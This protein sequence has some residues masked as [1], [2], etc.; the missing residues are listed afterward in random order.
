MASYPTYDPS[1]WIGGVTQE[2]VQG[3]SSTATRCR[4]TPTRACSP[5]ARR[6]RSSA[7]PRP[8]R[9][10]STS[11]GYVPL[12]EPG[13]RRR[14]RRSATSSRRR[15]AP[16]RL[17][18]RDRG[19]L[20]HGLLRHRRAHVAEGRRPGRRHR[21]APTRS[22]RRPQIVRP[23][24]DDRHRPA[25][26]GRRPRRPAA[27]FK[28]ANWE[29]MKDTLVRQR[30]GGLSRRRARPT[31]KLADY[32]TALDKENCTDGYQWRAGDALN[33]AIGQGDTSGHAAAD[34]DGLRGDRQR[35]HAVPAAGRQ[36][37]RQRGTATSSRSSSRSSRARVDVP[38]STHEVPARSRCPA[39][40]RDGSGETPFVGFP[41]DQIPVASKTGS[42]QVTGRRR[43]H[44]VVRVVR[45]GE[46]AR[47]TR[48]S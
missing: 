47:A 26:R 7:R 40:R 48:S 34:G 32:F 16:S 23:R 9:R 3:R 43:L 45:A 21:R 18:A 33:A 10:A 20:Q 15:T 35:R 36:G 46:Q 13:R 28:A 25:R 30:R 24:L 6:T 22:P 14:R 19:V 2:A 38:K 5:R 17:H 29:E 31:R 42:A 44:L 39:S 27:Q 12:P 37:D 8:A 11:Y 4:P 1:I 41:L